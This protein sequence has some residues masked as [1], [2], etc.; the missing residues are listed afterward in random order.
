MT[1]PWAPGPRPA[2]VGGAGRF[3]RLTN[4]LV[5]EAPFLAGRE[6]PLKGSTDNL[7]FWTFCGIPTGFHLYSTHAALDALTGHFC[8][9]SGKTLCYLLKT[10][11][12]VNASQL[13]IDNLS[14]PEKDAEL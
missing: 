8:L 10:K 2:A 9:S 5:W 4:M 13:G 7:W 12:T 11:A 14:L 3:S 6:G 1:V